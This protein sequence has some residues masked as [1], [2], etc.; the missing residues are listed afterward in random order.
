MHVPKKWVFIY[1]E[2]Q[3]GNVYPKYVSS[4]QKNKDFII[5]IIICNI[6]ANSNKL[7]KKKESKIAKHN[8]GK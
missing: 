8:S 1:C 3:G 5:I 7:I 4:L 6:R 2:P